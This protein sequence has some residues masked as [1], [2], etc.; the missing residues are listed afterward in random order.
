MVKLLLN[1]CEFPLFSDMAKISKGLVMHSNH[2]FILDYAGCILLPSFKNNTINT[3]W[4]SLSPSLSVSAS[5]A[6]NSIDNISSRKQELRTLQTQNFS[7]E[8]L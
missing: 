1:Q 2:E 3:Q 5:E 4:I 6:N 8:P 7:L